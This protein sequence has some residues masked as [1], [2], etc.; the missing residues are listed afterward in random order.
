MNMNKGLFRPLHAAGLLAV[1]ALAL[2]LSTALPTQATGPGARHL[3]GDTGH[4]G[5]GAEA[6]S[7]SRVFCPRDT[8][9]RSGG[10]STTHWDRAPGGALRY[11][12]LASH[13]LVGPDGREG[14]YASASHAEI[15]AHVLCAPS[16]DIA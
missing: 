7:V 14:W 13:P 10:Y 8:D 2:T 1:S 6:V 12:V 9:V 16:P 15:T 5:A 3:S 11:T 4:K